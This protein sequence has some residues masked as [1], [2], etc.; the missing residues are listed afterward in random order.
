MMGLT[1]VPNSGIVLA[2]SKN[3][4]RFPALPKTQTN[5]QNKFL[6]LRLSDHVDMKN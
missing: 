1:S 2:L 5:F 6:Q 3:V 4:K